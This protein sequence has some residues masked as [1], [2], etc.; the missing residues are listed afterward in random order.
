MTTP[1]RHPPRL[2]LDVASL[3][4]LVIGLVFGVFSYWL[5]DVR[6]ENILV[7]APAL[8]TAAMGAAHLLKKQ[9]PRI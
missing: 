6:G 4:L 2:R 3:V 7:M 5:V 8:V 1:R 9:A